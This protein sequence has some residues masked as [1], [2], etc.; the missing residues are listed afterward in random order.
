MQYKHKEIKILGV[1]VNA[2]LKNLYQ[3]NLRKYKKFS[4]HKLKRS[5]N[6]FQE[7]VIN[8]ENT[9]KIFL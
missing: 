6:H 7:H 9:S 3:K 8:I 5:L 4:N 1:I 2:A